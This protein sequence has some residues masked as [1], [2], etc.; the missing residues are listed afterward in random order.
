MNLDLITFSNKE[1]F[2]NIPGYYC[3]IF[4]NLLPFSIEIKGTVVFDVKMDVNKPNVFIYLNQ[5]TGSFMEELDSKLS[6]F[7]GNYVSP[8]KVLKN[9]KKFIDVLKLKLLDF[10]EKEIL[11]GTQINMCIH[12]S[13]IWFS[14]NSYGPYLNITSIKKIEIIR[15]SYFIDE[16]SDTESI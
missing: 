4:Y 12:I 10:S 11:R 5:S 7:E 13:G 1:R 15:E 8:R 14:E 16:E 6:I 9:K 2:K 3:N